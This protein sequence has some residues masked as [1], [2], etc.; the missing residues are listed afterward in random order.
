MALLEKWLGKITRTESNT[1]ADVVRDTKR[2]MRERK[3]AYRAIMKSCLNPCPEDKFDP[4]T[5][6]PMYDA[7]DYDVK[8]RVRKEPP[9]RLPTH[10]MLPKEMFDGQMI[11]MYESKQDLY[12]L[13]AWLS[14]R[15]SN[16]EDAL[17]AANI[18]IPDAKIK[19]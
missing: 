13:I 18:E 10:G 3:E 9:R 16:L 11:G 12:L 19:K 6:D 4:A 7:P 15:V 1:L 17:V 14:E 5:F 8:K 2:P